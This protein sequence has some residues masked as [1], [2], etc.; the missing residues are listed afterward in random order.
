MCIFL[1]RQLTDNH[2]DYSDID[3][4]VGRTRGFVCKTVS[5]SDSD[6][7]GNSSSTPSSISLGNNSFTSGSCITRPSPQDTGIVMSESSSTS[8]VLAADAPQPD[9]PCVK[10]ALIVLEDMEAT[11]YQGKTPFVDSLLTLY[12]RTLEYCHAILNCQRCRSMSYVIALLIMTCEKLLTST[13]LTALAT[14]DCMVSEVMDSS[15][16]SSHSEPRLFLGE[17]E[18]DSL[19]ERAQM[20]GVLK[21]IQAKKMANLLDQVESLTLENGWQ[22]QLMMVKKLRGKMN[23]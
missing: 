19:D 23:M 5:P 17:Y 18:I 9:C 16:N 22:A 10:Q 1:T 21:D 13:H 20:V 11:K 3:V 4:P 14:A 15:E 8:M 7:L 2:K 6:K 12:K